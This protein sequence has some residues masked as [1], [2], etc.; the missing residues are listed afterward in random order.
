[1]Y[2]LSNKTYKMHEI[3]HPWNNHI[4]DQLF[5]APRSNYLKSSSLIILKKIILNARSQ[6]FC[7]H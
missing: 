4:R 2:Y 3:M 6:V 1:M 7:K 5:I